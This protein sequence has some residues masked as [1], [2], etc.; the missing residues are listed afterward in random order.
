[1]TAYL[2]LFLFWLEENL[3]SL[4]FLIISGSL[5]YFI[6]LLKIDQRQLKKEFLDIVKALRKHSS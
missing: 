4:V 3:G 1:M 6:S 2:L 5:V